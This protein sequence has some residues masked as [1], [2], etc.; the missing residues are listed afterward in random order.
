VY[1]SG[2]AQFRF[3]QD[4]AY[5]NCALRSYSNDEVFR[6][7][8]NWKA[9]Y[10]D[11]SRVVRKDGDMVGDTIS[12][13]IAYGMMIGVY[14][15]D[16]AMFDSLWSYA[17]SHSNQNGFM[18]WR[19]G[20]GGNVVGQNGATDGDEDMA[21][22]LLMASVQWDMSYRQQ[23]LTL[24]NNIWQFE[25][26][27]GTQDV[28]KPGDMFGGAQETNPSYFAP[29]YYRVF[30]QV[31][32]QSGWMRVVDSSYSIIER[33]SGSYGLVPNWCDANGAPRTNR[34]NGGDFGY[35]ACRTP[36]RIALDYCENN[37]PRAK[38]YLDKLMGFYASKNGF[39]GIKDGYTMTGGDPAGTLGDYTVGMAFIGPAAAGSLISSSYDSIGLSAYREIANGTSDGYVGNV[40]TSF[41]YYNASWGVLGILVVSGN[42]WNLMR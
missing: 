40:T 23:A 36:W 17:R 38:A 25:V 4:R 15:N 27:H 22:A 35:D 28:L 11:G 39:I 26:E 14:M 1:N 21:W 5:P 34:M 8:K 13:G 31:S 20:P 12:E 16:R 19:I 10:Y 37:E 24:I 32:G 6:A 2:P 3:P 42:F 7:Y 41:S 33:A 30:A 18:H 9:T 29:S